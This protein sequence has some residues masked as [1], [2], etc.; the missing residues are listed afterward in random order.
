M[1]YIEF[2]HYVLRA[3]HLTETFETNGKE[4]SLESFRKIRKLLNFRKANYSTEIPGGKAIGTVIRG[5]KFSKFQYSSQDCLQLRKFWKLLFFSS[6]AILGIAKISNA[7]PIQPRGDR[8]EVSGSWNR[9]KDHLK[10]YLLVFIKTV[11]YWVILRKS[12]FKH[13]DL[14]IVVERYKM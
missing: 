4:F 13:P 3:F 7:T 10:N 1:E 5:K 8:G 2:F 6:L 11:I 14:L 12:F 9:V